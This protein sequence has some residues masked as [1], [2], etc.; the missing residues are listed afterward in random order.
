MGILAAIIVIGILVTVHELGHFAT[1]KMTGMRVEEFAIGFG[2]EIFSFKKGET[3]YSLRLVPLGGYNKISGMEPDLPKPGDWQNV[4][5]KDGRGFNEKSIP[6]RFLVIVAGATMNFLLPILI[7]A[8]TSF[9]VGVEDI[10]EQPYLGQVQE[11]GSAYSAGIRSGD[12]LLKINDKKIQNWDN[13]IEIIRDNGEKEL[14][15]QVKREKETKIFKMTPKMN[16]EYGRAMIGIAPAYEVKQLGIFRSLQFGV[17]KTFLT[18]KYMCKGIYDIIFGSAPADLS[19]PIGVA[20][21][22]GKVASKGSLALLNFTAF[23]SINLGII[24]LLPLP[25]LDGGHAI[26]LLL[27]GLRGKPLPA[28]AMEYIQY[29]GIA[30]ILAITLFATYK[31][32]LRF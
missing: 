23:L 17:E 11:S 12:L 29:A 15:V 26:L 8:G 18:M 20:M 27:E 25:A 31:D 6:A 19:G 2:P 1:A 21:V 22:A 3:K 16:K 7:Y 9:F 32:L 28:K 14:T 30:L 13:V 10:T 24:N 4:E 5:T